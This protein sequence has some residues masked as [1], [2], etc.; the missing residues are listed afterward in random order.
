MDNV[1][2][3]RVIISQDL[4]W[5]HHLNTIVK[6]A[7]QRLYLLRRLRDFK[8]PLKVLRN[9]Y[10]CTIASILCGSIT[11]WMGNCTRQDF[12]A[13]KRVVRS[14]ERTIRTPLPNLQDI[15]TKRCRLRAKKILKQHSHP[16]H[17]L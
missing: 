3:L 1:R 8:L 12:M 11:T 6:K 4:S 16:G 17:A 10:T 9:F 15:Y 13:L 5:T 2:Y 7:R 14:A